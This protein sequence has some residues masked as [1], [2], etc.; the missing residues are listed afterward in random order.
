MNQKKELLKNTL[1]IGIGKFSSQIVIFL[2]LPL[3]TNF[4]QADQYG[5]Y[6]TLIAIAAFIIPFITLL[7]EESMFRF[8]IE[9]SNDSEKK[10]EVISTA[11]FYHIIGLLIFSVIYLVV[12]LLFDFSFVSLFYFYIIV[13]VIHGLSNAIA[14]GTSNIKLYSIS[15]FFTNILIVILN[16]L[17]IA[18]LKLG[19][20]GLFLSYILGNLITSIYVFFKINLKDYFCLKKINANMTK[21]MIR[22]S[23]PLVPNSI[24]WNIINLSDRIMLTYMVSPNANGI[25]SVSNKF[26]QILGSIYN[27]FSTAWKESASKSV[28]NEK[29]YSEIFNMILRVLFIV[30]IGLLCALPL[31]YKIFV[32][33]EY[34]YSYYYV[35]ILVIAMVFSNI[36]EFYSGIFIAYKE[37]K[38][39]G[40]TTVIAAVLNVIVNFLF[41]RKY[42]IIIAAM[43]TL[44]STIT[45]SIIRKIKLK[46]YIYIEYKL[47]FIFKYSVLIGFSVIFFYLRK[48]IWNII[49]DII[50]LFILFLDNKTYINKYINKLRG[51][52]INDL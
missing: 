31:C 38:I 36:A 28:G 48:I 7:L 43:S 44:I 50:I 26:P 27:F 41:I 29:Y 37:T 15:N 34:F 49:F 16:I 3:Y 4:L 35:P 39:I 42:G 30:T 24:S 1:I 47:S 12:A 21:E 20:E 51:K 19:V 46:K 32:A 6:D 33:D 5:M 18:V 17:T 40:V 2:M 25:Y 22:Y 23:I 13:N 45:I 52:K 11:V 8:L 10:K 9:Y 14:R